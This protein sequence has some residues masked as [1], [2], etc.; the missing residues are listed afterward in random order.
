MREATIHGLGGEALRSD[1]LGQP[2]GSADSSQVET[3]VRNVDA[4][5]T[6]VTII[7]ELH[8]YCVL[9]SRPGDGGDDHY[10]QLASELT[11]SLSWR[12][13]ATL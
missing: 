5:I 11:L 3:K 1:N 2:L 12:I 10:N 6:I 7:S 8:L 4:A 9:V 13:L